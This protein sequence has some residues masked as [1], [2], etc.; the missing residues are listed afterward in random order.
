MGTTTIAKDIITM[1]EPAVYLEK[2]SAFSRML[3]LDGFAIGP[4]ETADAAQLLTVLGFEDRE[5]VKTALR[6]V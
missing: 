6:T 2:I 1:V 3:R 5:Q 4:Q